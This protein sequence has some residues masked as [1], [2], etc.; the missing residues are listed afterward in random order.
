MTGLSGITPGHAPRCR[1]MRAKIHRTEFIIE[2]PFILHP[3]HVLLVV[4]AQRYTGAAAVAEH[5][6]RAL[7]A[8]GV[9]ADLLFVGGGNLEARLAG[10]DWGRAE[11]RKERNPAHFRGNL[12][13][14]RSAA[15]EVDVVVCHLPHDHFLCWAAGVHRNATLV[16]SYRRAKHLRSNIPNRKLAW[17]IDAGLLANSSL[18]QPFQRLTGGTVDAVSLPVPLEERFRPGREGNRWR[19][20][21]GI[22]ETAPVLGMI[23]KV[24][25]GR[26][27]DTLL[28]TVQRVGRDAHVLIVGH[29]EARFELEALATS[30]GLDGR[31]HWAGYRARELPELYAAMD[32]VLF[33]AAGSDHGHRAVSEAQ[34]CG[35]PVVSAEIPGVDDLIKDGITG[36]IVPG[37]PERLAEAVVSL[38]ADPAA[39]R[40]I[41]A[42]AADVV[43]SRRFPVVGRVLASFLG[44]LTR[45]ASH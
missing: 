14:V 33:P 12:A 2:P 8:A 39:A 17:I 42:A 5:N 18:A 6:C 31:V 35:R 36:R 21:L 23:G 11:L 19:H 20:N 4:A 9:D 30:L 13:R 44:R 32:V 26:G 25:R 43:A 27:F 45:S 10:F 3:M 29:G 7:H 16:R 28:R 22:S 37:S 34:G 40:R 24:A 38:L 1:E 15:A 41:G